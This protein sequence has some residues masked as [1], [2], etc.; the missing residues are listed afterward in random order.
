[1]ALL[2]RGQTN[3]ARGRNSKNG[4]RRLDISTSC[5]AVAVLKGLSVRLSFTRWLSAERLASCVKDVTD[6]IKETNRR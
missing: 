2:W 5:T 6:H 1:M 4:D 3:V